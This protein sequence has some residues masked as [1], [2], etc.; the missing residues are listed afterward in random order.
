MKIKKEISQ[1][2]NFLGRKRINQKEELFAAKIL[3]RID[4]DIKIQF[5]YDF[6]AIYSNVSIDPKLV[7]SELVLDVFVLGELTRISLDK[8][9]SSI[10]HIISD[11]PDGANLELRLKIISVDKNL[12]GR[13]F[14]ATANKMSLKSKDDGNEDNTN[15]SS[16][17]ILNFDQSDDLN[18]RLIHVDWTPDSDIKI[19]IDRIFYEKYKDKSLFR[20][21]VYPDL[22]RSIA[23]QLISH[24]DELDQLDESSS[25]FDWLKYF[26]DKLDIPLL[27]QDSIFHTAEITDAPQ[28]IDTIVE[29]FMSK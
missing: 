24:H 23:I 5:K 28:A 2:F 18:G 26:S 9:C 22:I 8:A 25:A 4:Q 19:K 17:G 27:G 7:N 15:T 1:S 13:I 16:N 6:S 3:E 21:A 10:D 11:V 20:A 29:T 12:P 14:A